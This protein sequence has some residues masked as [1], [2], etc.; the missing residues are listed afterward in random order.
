MTLL[1]DGRE[2]ELPSTVKV[3]DVIACNELFSI[4][5]DFETNKLILKEITND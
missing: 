4:T 1:I 5:Y 2:V 3:V